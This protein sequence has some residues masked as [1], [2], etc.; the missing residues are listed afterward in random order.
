MDTE[1]KRTYDKKA[2]KIL[3]NKRIPGTHFAKGSGRIEGQ[4]H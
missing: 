2:K 3:S 1:Q 4:I